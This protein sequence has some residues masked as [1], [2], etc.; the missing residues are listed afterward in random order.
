MPSGRG[1]DAHLAR[2]AQ[3]DRSELRL[4]SAELP[5]APVTGELELQSIRGVLDVGGHVGPG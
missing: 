3:V 1:V 2:G 4:E 5:A